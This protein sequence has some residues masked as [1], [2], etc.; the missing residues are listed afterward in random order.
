MN[1]IFKLFFSCWILPLLG[2]FATSVSITK[3]IDDGQDCMVCFNLPL[4]G[5]YVTGGDT[6][7]LTKA[8]QDALF[9]GNAVQL[10]TNL[11]PVNFDLWDTSGQIAYAVYPVT[12]T[13]QNNYK[14]KF[15]ASA[16]FGTELAAGAYPATLLAS[17]IQGMAVFHKQQ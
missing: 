10:P 11:I 12:G 1:S 14:V 8:V 9:Q 2:K 4:S 6:V 17:K 5:N 15:S 3:I 13:A 7:D 16:T